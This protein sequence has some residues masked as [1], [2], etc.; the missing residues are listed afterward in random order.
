MLLR[1]KK[2]NKVKET[3]A[4][5]FTVEVSTSPIQINLSVTLYNLLLNLP[6]IFTISKQK[7]ENFAREIEDLNLIKREGVQRN[8]IFEGKIKKQNPRNLL[9]EDFY[10]VLSGKY[11]YLYK[12]K[13]SQESIESF[14]I[15]NVDV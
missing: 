10:A 13:S 14:D 12:E 9:W 1:L 7:R 3:N 15:T 8:A 4:A 6:N 5:K 11:V 2:K